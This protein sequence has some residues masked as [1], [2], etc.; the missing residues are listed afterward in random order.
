MAKH[1]I[2]VEFTRQLADKGKVLEAGWQGVEMLLKGATDA[3]RYQAKMI[4]YVGAQHIFTSVMN[5]L[6]PSV[7]GNDEPT[8]EDLSRISKLN[9]ELLAIEPLLKAW[10]KLR[11]DLQ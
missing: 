11:K 6:D 10:A 3:E 5:F 1:S 7:A 9:D 2:L 4:Y 8:D